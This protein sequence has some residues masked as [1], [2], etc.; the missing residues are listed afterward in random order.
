MNRL[1]GFYAKLFRRSFLKNKSHFLLNLA[2]LILGISCFLFSLLYFTYETSYDNYHVNR[3]RIARIVTTVVAGGN[4]MHTALSNGFLAPNLPKRYPRIETMVRFKPFSGRAAI[5]TLNQREAFTLEKAFYADSDV[6][7]VFSYPLREGDRATCLLAPN[8]IVLSRQTA[9]RLF[10]RSAAMNALVTINDQTL[11]VTG[12]MDDL[13]GNSDITFDGLI[14]WNTLPPAEDDG[15]VYTYVL[16][17]SPSGIAGLQAD[18]DSFTTKYLNPQLAN[19][20]T[21]FSYKPEPLSLLHFSNSYVYDT[22]KGNKVSLDIFLT[23]GILILVIACTNSV[24]MMVVRSFARS[25]EVTMQKIYGAGRR[26]LVLQQL[27]ESLIVGIIAIVLSI[28]LVGLLLPAFGAMVN[29][30]IVLSDLLN[31]KTGAA[32]GAALIVLAGSGAVYS[33]LYLQRV[34][35]ADLLRSKNS[36][37]QGMRIVPKMMLGFQFF[38]SIGMIVAGL[39][40][41]RQVSYLRSIPLGFDPKNVLVVGLPQGAYA[42]KGDQYLKNELRADPDV[43]KLALCGDKA[44]PGQFADFDVMQYREHGVLVNKGVDD[45]SV[46]E[47][48]LSLLGLPMIAGSGF[49]A[50]KDS[51]SSHQVIVTELFARE[52]GWDHPIGQ[53][54]TEGD[55]K[56]QVVGVVPDFHFGSLHRPIE[57]MV[58]FQAPADPAY[59]MVK[60]AGTKA[61]AVI[62]QLQGAWSKAF[63]AF[64]FAYFSLEE[65]LLRQYKDEGNLLTLLVSLSLLVIAISCI[66][67]IAYTSYIIRMSMTGIAIRRIIGASFRDIF[68]L[69]NRQFVLLLVIGLSVAVPVSWYLLGRWLEQFAY[70]VNVRPADYIVAAGAMAAIVGGV[71]LRYIARCIRVSPAKIIREQ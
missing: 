49:Q 23:L 4:V 28:L 17:K 27:L 18:L 16:L 38:I 62:N 60:V 13:P 48:Y 42:A 39:L 47:D 33:G 58:I 1:A 35:L 34:N 22:P 32:L 36:K 69:F 8:T 45:I 61:G 25:L 19:S 20:K 65:H 6:F 21:A 55:D 15:F 9:K 52:A 63:P 71:V 54:I 5:R 53:L 14:S 66:G 43:L 10:G 12:I 57:P 2:G 30:P 26:Q 40:V 7:K 41:F 24:N 64:P 50:V 11:K 68:N 59:L 29:R 3:D 51:S 37:G 46:D 67:L 31:W 44:L 56:V 70:H